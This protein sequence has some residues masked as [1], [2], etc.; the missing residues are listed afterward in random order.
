MQLCSSKI[1]VPDMDTKILQTRR[2][3]NELIQFLLLL[4]GQRQQNLVIF[5]LKDFKLTG[6][7]LRRGLL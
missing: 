5:L 3:K 7:K 1:I 6:F 2:Y 4:S